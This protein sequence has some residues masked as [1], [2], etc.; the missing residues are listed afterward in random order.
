MIFPH[1]PG[2]LLVI[3]I[4]CTCKLIALRQVQQH[5]SSSG[6][7]LGR[8]SSGSN[9]YS[10]HP[11]HRYFPFSD[12][13]SNSLFILENECFYRDPPPSYAHA[14]ASDC[15]R[16]RRRNPRNRMRPR[17]RRR[18]PTPPP[19]TASPDSETS[20]AL[21]VPNRPSTE[22]SLHLGETPLPSNS[23]EDNKNSDNNTKHGDSTERSELPDDLSPPSPSNNCSSSSSSN[24]NI[25]LSNIPSP[26]TDCDQ[27]PLL[28]G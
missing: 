9:L 7:N 17:N 15:D 21:I 6:D 3:A 20:E 16:S 14:V 25:E 5:H 11:Y 19:L 13:T 12:Q 4:S 27:Q 28:S 22:I 18:P 23:S 1:F 10:S 2:V 26:Q 8:G 24:V